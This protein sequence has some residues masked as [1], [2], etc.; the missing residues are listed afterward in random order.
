MDARQA[1][2][3]LKRPN[4]DNP[5]GYGAYNVHERIK[6]YFGKEYG[7]CVQSVLGTGTKI[8]IR[9]PGGGERRR[10]FIER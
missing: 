6:L 7:V 9:I 2:E 8:T 4:L 1:G 10:D 3:L 5:G